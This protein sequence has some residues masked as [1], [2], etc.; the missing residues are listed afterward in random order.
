MSQSS[1]GRVTA[2]VSAWRPR[3]PASP[4]AMEYLVALELSPDA[5]KFQPLSVPGSLSMELSVIRGFLLSRKG[6]HIEAVNVLH[7]NMRQAIARWGKT[8]FQVG[9]AAAESATC[10]NMLR[11][12]NVANSIATSLLTMRKSSELKS[13]RD[14]FC[15]ELT[16]IDSLIGTGSYQEADL[17]LRGIMGQQSAPATTRTMCCLRLSKVAAQLGLVDKDLSRRISSRRELLL[18]WLKYP[19]IQEGGQARLAKWLIVFDDIENDETIHKL[20]PSYSSGAVL[21]TSRTR[22]SYTPPHVRAGTI[23]DIKVQSLAT[24]QAQEFLNSHPVVQ[25]TDLL[26]RED[27]PILADL[28]GCLLSAMAQALSFISRRCLSL[29]DFIHLYTTTQLSISSQANQL[30]DH[31]KHNLAL[32]ILW[33]LDDSK[34]GKDLL[35]VMCL[36]SNS[37]IPESFLRSSP[38]YVG[39]AKY[40]GHVSTFEEARREL[41]KSS[42]IWRGPDMKTLSTSE[43]MQIIGKAD[44]A[45]SFLGMAATVL[46]TLRQAT[47]S[48][49]TKRDVEWHRRVHYHH[50]GW[51]SNYRTRYIQAEMQFSTDSMFDAPKLLAAAYNGLAT[52]YFKTERLTESTRFY[53][54]CITTLECMHENV[55]RNLATVRVNLGFALLCHEYPEEAESLFEQA[56]LADS[57]AKAPHDDSHVPRIAFRLYGLALAKFRQGDP[58]RS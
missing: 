7:G 32:I 5:A 58:E 55:D 16:R 52:V 27:I 25:D 17:A 10:H 21:I 31:P 13:R 23:L 15:L 44:E 46:E 2:A 12:E 45:S 29:R 22:Y 14:W 18:R 56:V 33:L 11:Q 57:D 51:L 54:D 47:P 50:M 38:A 6:L 35:D 41:L 19:L 36:V 20:W 53:R 28:L 40:S 42:L 34:V 1:F 30:T 4:S 24:A 8:S 9:I 26:E 3:S 43:A 49:Q 48:A 37:D 39:W